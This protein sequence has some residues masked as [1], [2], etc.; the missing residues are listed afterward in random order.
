MSYIEYTIQSTDSVKDIADRFGV[1]LNELVKLNPQVNT[2]GPQMGIKIKVPVSDNPCL[3]FYGQ[4]KAFYGE[5]TSKVFSLI[6]EI[7]K[8]CRKP[9]LSIEEAMEQAS[10]MWSENFK[11][12]AFDLLGIAKHP[13][14]MYE[15]Y[16]RKHKIHI[17]RMKLP[18]YTQAEIEGIESE[19][20]AIRVNQ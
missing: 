10:M 16:A 6:Y 18:D 19:F 8:D 5:D 9:G 4:L 7:A 2:P 14:V 1:G 15:E 12:H 17:E 13:D 20:E 3:K 11:P